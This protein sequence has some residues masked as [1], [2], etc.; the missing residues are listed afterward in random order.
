MHI[1]RIAFIIAALGA[2]ILNVSGQPKAKAAP[3]FEDY[4][5]AEV[6]AGHA[7]HPNIVTSSQRR[8]RTRIREGVE[9]GWGV[10]RDGVEQKQPGPNFAGD[11]IFIQWGCGVP[12][13]MAALVNARTGEVFNPPLAVDGTLAL[14]LLNIGGDSGGRNPELEFRK[15]SRL[16]I[17]SATPNWF[18]GHPRSYRHY[19]VW[20][21][22]RWIL[23]YKESLD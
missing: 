21:S 17:V 19:F 18:K 20:E 2:E 15:N 8:Y 10:F 23:V 9:K 12:C 11:I 7:V 13:L 4:P 22:N 14:P 6:F 16:M 1:A 3:R 5:A